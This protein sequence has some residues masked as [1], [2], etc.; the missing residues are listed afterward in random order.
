MFKISSFFKSAFKKMPSRNAR[1]ITVKKVEPDSAR[2]RLG[3]V[4]PF[5][6]PFP[7]NRGSALKYV[8]KKKEKKKRGKKRSSNKKAVESE[9]DSSGV[10]TEKVTWTSE[11]EKNLDDFLKDRSGHGYDKENENTESYKNNGGY[12]ARCSKAYRRK[13]SRNTKIKRYWRTKFEKLK[14]FRQRY[15]FWQFELE[16]LTL[17]KRRYP[18]QGPARWKL[19]RNDKTAGRKSYL[20][21]MNKQESSSDDSDSDSSSSSSD[22]DLRPSRFEA[23]PKRIPAA[24]PPPAAPVTDSFVRDASGRR[25]RVQLR[26]RRSQKKNL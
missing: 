14:K 15:P 23:A 25:V 12:C 2:K 5:K 22:S 11:D 16:D 24:A 10:S 18:N 7:I 19:S 9:S 8:R 6:V 26:E 4:R 17:K 20:K 1:S 21:K 13:D 3:F